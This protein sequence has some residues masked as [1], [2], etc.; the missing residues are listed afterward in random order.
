MF[1]ALELDTAV[2]YATRVHSEARPVLKL[3][4]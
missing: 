2:P 1:S 4:F 3:R